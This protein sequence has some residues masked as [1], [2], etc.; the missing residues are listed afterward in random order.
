MSEGKQQQSTY[1]GWL[2]KWTNY[3]KGYQK[4]W[5]VLQNGLLSYYRNQ[6]EMTHT[7]RGTINLATAFIT[8]S[9]SCTIVISS[10][11]NHTFHLKATS[12]VDRQK[13][14]TALELAKADAIRMLE[15][16][17]DEEEPDKTDIQTTIKSLNSKLEDLNT[18]NDLIGKHGSA[19]QRALTELEQL[20]GAPDVSSKT[21][22]INERATM[23]R[24]TSNAMINA[25]AEFLEL[26]QTD[27]KRW[28]KM[29][30]HEYN[31][32]LKLQELLEQLAKDQNS[33]EIQAKKSMLPV[34]ADNPGNVV[35]GSE[36]D[37]FEDALDYQE[38]VTLPGAIQTPAHRRTDSDVSFETKLFDG[39]E[40]ST[41][42]DIDE[43][44]APEQTVAGVYQT[45]SKKLKKKGNKL[46]NSENNREP[47]KQPTTALI[48]K[49]QRRLTI[50]PKPNYSLNLWGIMKNCIGKE[51]SKIPMPVNFSEP[52]SMLQRIT[53]DFEYSSLLDEAA[54][55]EDST[56]Q[57][58]YVT[59]FTIS[60]FSTTI[61][62]TTKPFNPLLGETYECDRM[63]DLGWRSIAEQVSHHPPTTC[64]HTE[65]KK[66]TLWQEFTMG[67]KF[68]GAYLNIVPT[69]IAHLVFEKSGNHYTWRKVTTT[70]HN[71]IVGKLWVDHHG[72]MDI[73]NHKTG[74]NCHLK[75]YPYSY[76]SR[77]KPRKVTGVVTDA[78]DA[79]KW[80]ITGT[81]DTQ[82]EVAQV[83][84][85]DESS[86]RPVFATGPKRLLWKRVLP[87][88]GSDK[89]YFF[90]Q[91][92][93]QLNEPEDDVAPT[94]SRKRPDERHMENGD[95]DEANRVKVQLEE[96][97][98]TKRKKMEAEAE[99]CLKRGEEP[100][101]HEPMW[102]KR[103]KDEITGEPIYKS[104]DKYWKCKESQDWTGC[105]D[106][107]L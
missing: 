20:E 81:W 55:C 84:Q 59:V 69:G 90:T 85:V 22:V 39:E 9:D 88:P 97:Q 61:N 13:W 70:V 28:H 44:D 34:T 2:Y 60:S 18:C 27:G 65:G 58:A 8:T 99:A 93:I 106:I 3:L 89:M 4:R 23:F 64:V 103:S 42:S 29:L 71:I 14:V 33:L 101:C 30:E 53:E 79:A 63:D 54:E 67:S 37:D 75:Y 56:E 80:V 107:Y 16:D 25:C 78:N 19:L 62:R 24:I 36:E 92:A 15:P 98:R 83:L 48:P 10:G 105:P 21:K 72:E 17:S 77:D 91:L 57:L 12:E 45:K 49:K 82:M 76:F 11:G 73:K 102:F 1:K 51:L 43:A 6:A 94:D 87:P 52:L 5:F 96:K 46:G 7:C 31:Q 35:S 38:V 26:A 86:K 32:K 47:P 104:T 40:Y 50:P 41:E 66:W 100:P 68:R 74:D 95:W